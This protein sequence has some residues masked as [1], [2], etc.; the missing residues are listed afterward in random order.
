M[1][2]FLFEVIEGVATLTLN[3]PDSLNALTPEMTDGLTQ[4]TQECERNPS[5]RCVVL[6]GAGRAFMAGG[7]VKGMHAAL[8]SDAEAQARR[9]EMRVMR[10]HQFITHIRRMHKPVVAAVH[11]AV[12]GIGFGIAM[13]ADIVIARDDAFFV[14][15]YRHIGLTADGGFT[16]FV[17]RII[18]ER[19]ALEL[20]MFGDRLPAALA[21]QLGLVNWVVP[22]E[23][24]DGF[25]SEKVRLLADGPT[26]AL[27]RVKQLIRSSLDNSWDQQS[28]Q[29]AESIAALSISADHHEG[30][31]AFVEKRPARFV[32]R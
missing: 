12:A 18:G 26:L 23:E 20:S 15:A 9:M 29:E 22:I 25:V 13:S 2:H 1:E 21:Q 24:F 31:S 8:S 4:A 10:A 6:R 14:A 16:H 30:V 28:R 27:G 5:I 17:P 11:G 3:R 7:D 19:K 32:G